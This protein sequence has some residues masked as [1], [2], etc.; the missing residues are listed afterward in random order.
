MWS[1]RYLISCQ[2]FSLRF[3]LQLTREGLNTQSFLH[4]RFHPSSVENPDSCG[5]KVKGT[6]LSSPAILACSPLVLCEVNSCFDFPVER[7]RPYQILRFLFNVVVIIMAYKVTQEPNC[8]TRLLL[9]NN[10]YH[11]LQFVIIA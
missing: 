5:I 6:S 7:P 1:F 3:C 10:L 11:T 9:I 4:M 2:T 8:A